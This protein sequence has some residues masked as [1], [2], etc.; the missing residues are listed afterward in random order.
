MG[1]E[2]CIRDRLHTMYL[3]EGLC[4]DFHEMGTLGF[5]FQTLAPNKTIAVTRLV[6]Y[7]KRLKITGKLTLD[8][9]S[10]D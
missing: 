10:G 9:R 7:L 6:A 3:A 5:S 2:M 4:W 1:S 8:D